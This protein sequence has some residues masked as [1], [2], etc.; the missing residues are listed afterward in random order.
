MSYAKYL[1][2]AKVKSLPLNQLAIEEKTALPIRQGEG[3]GLL[4]GM[5]DSQ[6]KFLGIGILR[7]VDSVRKT[8]KVFTSVSAKPASVAFGKVRLDENF[9]ETPTFLGENGTA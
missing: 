4:L 7:E 1:T 2:D 6:R 8:L 5:Y 3:D 9:K